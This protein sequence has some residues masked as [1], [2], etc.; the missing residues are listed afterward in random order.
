[1]I[2]CSKYKN[3][4][5]KYLDG[6]IA[7]AELAELKSHAEACPPCR[8]EFSHCALMQKAIGQALSS[9]ISARQARAALLEEL[10]VEPNRYVSSTWF[11]S[12]RVAVAAGILLTVG[13]LAGFALGR[14]SGPG[15]TV[16]PVTA[17]VP[18]RVAE[19]QGTVLVRHEGSELWRALGADSRIYLGDTFHATANSACILKLVGESTLDLKQNSMLVLRSYNGATQFRL[20]HGELT[21]ALESPHPPFFISTPHG[22][23][24]ALGTEFT[25]T[26]E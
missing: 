4:I 13:L 26:V 2:D 20:E 18:I 14:L 23:V 19:I 17:Q 8:E 5:E 21:A 3:L 15:K 12:R 25:V 16:T 6:I 10:P 1:M 24:E 9:G 11:V 7:E 22:R